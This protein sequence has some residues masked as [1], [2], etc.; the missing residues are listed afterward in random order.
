[1]VHCNWIKILEYFL[2]PEILILVPISGFVNKFPAISF[3]VLVAPKILKYFIL[4]LILALILFYGLF[5][6]NYNTAVYYSQQ[7]LYIIN[8]FYILIMGSG[9]NHPNGFMSYFVSISCARPSIP[10]RRSVLPQA[11]IIF[12]TPA[13]SASMT[14]HLK[15]LIE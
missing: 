11:I 2:F 5:A 10:F 7:S 3:V 6:S 4:P 15:Q 9:T 12:E 8:I 14:D 13:A 1:M